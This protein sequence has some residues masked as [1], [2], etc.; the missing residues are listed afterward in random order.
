MVKYK[1]Y[2]GDDLF[3]EDYNVGCYKLILQYHYFEIKDYEY[4][5]NKPMPHKLYEDYIIENVGGH[6]EFIFK[7]EWKNAKIKMR[8]IIENYPRDKYGYLWFTHLDMSKP[9]FEQVNEQQIN[10]RIYFYN[11]YF[12]TEQTNDVKRKIYSNLIA[13]WEKTTK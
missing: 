2:Y 7:D 10:E 11:N 3:D 6:K 12:E 1:N 9:R 13:L 5:K 4:W 8:D